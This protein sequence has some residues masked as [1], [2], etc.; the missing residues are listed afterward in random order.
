MSVAVAG[1]RV[2]WPCRKITNLFSR[3]LKRLFHLGVPFVRGRWFTLMPFPTPLTI[4]IGAPID[5]PPAHA[6][7]EAEINVWHAKYI[8]ALET[9][10]SAHQVACGYE[11][12]K[13][14]IR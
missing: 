13:L 14:V 7:T 11:D 1:L 12:T 10:Y 5:V 6:P 2:S 3:L 4:V 8:E 9:M